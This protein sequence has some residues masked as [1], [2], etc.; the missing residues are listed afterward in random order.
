MKNELKEIFDGLDSQEEKIG[1]ENIKDYRIC[2][3]CLEYVK[4]S[5]YNDHLTIEHGYKC[6][7]LIATGNGR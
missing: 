6:I 3:V 2:A 1:K 4:R 5:E 7:S